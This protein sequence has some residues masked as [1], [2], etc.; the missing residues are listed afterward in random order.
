M[1]KNQKIIIYILGLNAR[2]D[3]LQACI[4]NSKIKLFKNEIKLRNQ[5]ALFM[6]NCFV[7]KKILFFFLKLKNITIQFML[8]IPLLLKIEK[9]Y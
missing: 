1:V 6:T 8:N 7:I 5:V 9:N 3:E 2:M 4:L